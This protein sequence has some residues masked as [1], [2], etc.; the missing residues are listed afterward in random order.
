MSK[1]LK[2]VINIS[3]GSPLTGN[4]WVD[5]LLGGEK[6]VEKSEISSEFN[7]NPSLVVPNKI[8]IVS[9][10][11]GLSNLTLTV[12]NNPNT[13]GPIQIYAI[14]FYLNDE[15]VMLNW[16]QAI[17]TKPLRFGGQPNQ[18]ITNPYVG[19]PKFNGWASVPDVS[20]GMSITWGLADLV[21]IRPV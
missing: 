13:I 8:E 17:K 18:T 3:K 5:I 7:S 2:A 12:I 21:T 1:Q 10:Y 20:P 6:L 4:A 16:Q 9:E 19:D 11:D 14:E 15:Q